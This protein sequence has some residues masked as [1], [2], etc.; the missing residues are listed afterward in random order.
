ML[1]QRRRG[2]VFVSFLFFWGFF[3]RRKTCNLDF[4]RISVHSRKRRL[5]PAPGETNSRSFVRKRVKI[6]PYY[7]LTRLKYNPLI[8]FGGTWPS[9]AA[10]DP[11]SDL[12]SGECFKTCKELLLIVSIVSSSPRHGRAL[13]MQ[14]TS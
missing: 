1:V 9:T 13:A 14:V 3:Q 8:L 2:S 7:I 10:V 11:A 6:P 12:S 4:R 5:L